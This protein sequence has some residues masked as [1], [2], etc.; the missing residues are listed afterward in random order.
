VVW[1]THRRAPWLEPALDRR[2]ADLLESA[3]RRAEG[4]VLLAAGN[5]ADHVH[6]LVRHP[7]RVAIATLVRRLKG[8][9]ARS[10]A[11]S[12]GRETGHIWQAGYW[13]QTVGP[14]EFRAVA[15]YVAN[16]RAH[17]DGLP[18]PREPWEPAASPPEG[19]A[20]TVSGRDEPLRRAPGFSPGDS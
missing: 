12:V 1:A 19:W 4:T 16:Q 18:V 9:S 5:A 6:V 10:L 2:L 17:H 15:A 20:S 3:A 13:A 8:S 14:S 11:A 7:P